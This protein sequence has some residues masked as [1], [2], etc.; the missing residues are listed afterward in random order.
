MGTY[1]HIAE[2]ARR[3]RLAA[4]YPNDDLLYEAARELER[5]EGNR[6]ELRTVLRKIVRVSDEFVK[7]TGMKHGDP[8]TDAVDAARPL[9]KSALNPAAAWPFPPKRTNATQ[10]PPEER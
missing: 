6:D 1:S 4:Y 8:L 2:L 7:D 10:S 5:L 3:L 9:I